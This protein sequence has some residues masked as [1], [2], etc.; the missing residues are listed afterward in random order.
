LRYTVSDIWIVVHHQHEWL[1]HRFDIWHKK[2]L[3]YKNTGKYHA[4]SKATICGNISNKD[5]ALNSRY[6]Q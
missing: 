1:I 2:A 5:G 3:S 4:A 6:Y